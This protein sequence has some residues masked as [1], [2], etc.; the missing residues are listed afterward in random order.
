MRN[1]VATMIRSTVAFG[2]LAALLAPIAGQAQ[3]LNINY[4]TIGETDQDANHLAGGV[5][6]NEVQQTLGADGLPLLN[7]TT[8]GCMSNC[9][10]IS[11]APTDVTSTGEITYWSPT[12]NRGGAGGTSDVVA[13]GSATV[14]L[15]F[16]VPQ[17]FYPPNGT[18]GSDYNGFQAATL[19]GT[20]VA[21]TTEQ[22]SF[23]I[24]SDDMAF[25]YLD[26]QLV[27]SDGGVHPSSA[28]ACVTPGDISA[29]SHSLELFFV[30]INNSQSGLTFGINTQG[31]TTSPPPATGAPEIDPASAGSGLALIVGGLLVIGGRTRRAVAAA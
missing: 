30:D 8:Y 22:I 26:G 20:L 12:L 24:G 13:T 21:P 15:P 10:A 1:Q 7:T 23:N 25:A 27:C 5:F 31:V 3:T 18:G 28:G 6:S 11:G 9:Y 19:T 14:A 17:N 4:F 29:G 16:S 2:I